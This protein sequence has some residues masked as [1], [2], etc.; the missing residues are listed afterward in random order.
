MLVN[1]D[2]VNQ[3][4]YYH[5]SAKSW[6]KKILINYFEKAEKLIKLF[7]FAFSE[8]DYN[9]AAFLLHQATERLYTAI[10]LVFTRYKPNTHDLVVTQEIEQFRR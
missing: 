9:E 10:L 5:K 7:N 4:N 2:S 8:E 3:K 6:L 1:T